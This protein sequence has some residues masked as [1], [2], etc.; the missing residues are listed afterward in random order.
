MISWCIG[1]N[2]VFIGV[3]DGVL[4]GYISCVGW[5]KRKGVGDVEV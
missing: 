4:E 5:R 3:Y 2:R 1:C